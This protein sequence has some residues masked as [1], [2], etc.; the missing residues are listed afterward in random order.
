MGRALLR[1]LNPGVG[2]PQM[3]QPAGIR[4]WEAVG[5]MKMSGSQPSDTRQ[6]KEKTVGAAAPWSGERKQSCNPVLIAV[7]LLN[8]SSRF[9][10]QQITPKAQGGAPRGPGYVRKCTLGEPSSFTRR[11]PDRGAGVPRLMST[12][13]PWNWN[14][15]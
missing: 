5:G 9:K 11:G 7:D 6:E 8:R 14:W 2:G 4:G 13:I 15:N 1:E 12:F 3:G 10:S